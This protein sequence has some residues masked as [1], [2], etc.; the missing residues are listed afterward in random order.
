MNPLNRSSGRRRRIN[1]YRAVSELFRGMND[2][3]KRSH[4]SLQYRFLRQQNGMMPDE[5]PPIGIG[6][7]FQIPNVVV[8][9]ARMG[10]V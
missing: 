6:C 7:V 4:G 1:V 3:L 8:A 10:E 5:N 9:A 2:F